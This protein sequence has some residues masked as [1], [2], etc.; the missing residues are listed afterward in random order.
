MWI[1]F[2]PMF[3]PQS[4]GNCEVN[5]TY[6]LLGQDHGMIGPLSK[7]LVANL[8]VDA[9][10]ALGALLTSLGCFTVD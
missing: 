10:H 2:A 9:L 6:R 4:L 5:K 1:A 8:Q 7:L 3:N